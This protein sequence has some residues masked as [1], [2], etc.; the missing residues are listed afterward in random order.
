MPGGRWWGKQTAASVGVPGTELQREM[1]RCEAEL[2][3]TL[4]CFSM[5]FS[6]Q[7]PATPSQRT[8]IFNGESPARLTTSESAQCARTLL[9][10]Q[11]LFPKQ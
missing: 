8:G 9:A 5:Y 11:A 3:F 1:Q 7:D 2:W 10:F 4:Q 6:G